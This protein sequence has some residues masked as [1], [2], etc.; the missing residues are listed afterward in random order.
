MDGAARLPLGQLLVE[1]GL[2]TQAELDAALAEQGRTQRPLGEILVEGGFVSGGAVANALAEQHGGLL[3][4]EYGVA[5]GLKPQRTEDDTPLQPPPALPG[6]P[7]PRWDGPDEHVAA[8][9]ARF[10]DQ[11]PA[12]PAAAPAPSPARSGDAAAERI[13]ALEA[14]VAVLEAARDKALAAAATAIQAL[15]ELLAQANWRR[16]AAEARCA[17]LEAELARVG[18][19]PALQTAH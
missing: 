1:A 11:R 5:V 9:A 19:Q 4:T 3:R 6:A 2:L 18:A 10:G 13:A 8:L 15:D 14:E 16:E 7:R 17:Q 12:A